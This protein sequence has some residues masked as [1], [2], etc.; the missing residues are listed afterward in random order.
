MPMSNK[1]V[2]KTVMGWATWLKYSNSHMTRSLNDLRKSGVVIT[3]SFSDSEHRNRRL[4]RLDYDAL[5]SAIARH[6]AHQCMTTI[7]KDI[8]MLTADAKILA[9]KSSPE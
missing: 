3:A 7:G 5:R 1:W 4:Y 8:A 9:L 6:E 2:H